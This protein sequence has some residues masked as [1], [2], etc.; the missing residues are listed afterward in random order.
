RLKLDW[1]NHAITNDNPIQLTYASRELTVVQADVR[2]DNSSAQFS[3]SIPLEGSMG[4]LKLDVRAN[5]AELANLIELDTPVVAAGQIL[6][7]GSVRGNLKRIEPDLTIMLTD[8]S[9]ESAAMFAPV[10]EANLKAVARD[11]RVVV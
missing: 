6:V 8:G 4:Q 7:S 3:G 5:L 1:R 9:V 2:M 11:G 10:R